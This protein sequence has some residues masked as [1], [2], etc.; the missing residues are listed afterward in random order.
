MKSFLTT[1]I[2]LLAALMIG[3]A[4][5]QGHIKPEVTSKIS[6]GMTKD[7]VIKAIG[8]PETVSSDGKT[9]MLS[10]TV[11]RPWW[12]WKPLKVKIVDG[13]VASYEVAE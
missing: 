11:E 1:S 10:Y 2:A 4:A 5:A 12:N 13:K 7:Q 3:C 6:V 9:E 8:L